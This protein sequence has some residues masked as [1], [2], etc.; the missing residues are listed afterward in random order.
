MAFLASIQGVIPILLII[1]LGYEMQDRHFVS[2]DFTDNVSKII[3][4]IALPAAVFASMVKY[5]SLDMLG[6]L[7]EGITLVGISV[8]LWYGLGWVWAKITHVPAGRNGSFVAA[9]ANTNTLFIGWPLNLALFGEQAMPY[10]LAY[11]FFCNI[12]CWTIGAFLVAEDP[13]LSYRQKVRRHFD[14]KK[15]VPP[16]LV[17]CVVAFAFL[18]T[19]I[20][21]PDALLNTFNYVGS[22]VTPL[23]LLY[24]GMTLQKAGI[25]NISL[26]R[27]TVASSW[28]RPSWPPS[29]S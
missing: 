10:F 28:R 17:S 12:S 4:N 14:L 5:M 24:I 6:S 2:D 8:L 7:S 9:V 26:D 21:L 19:G 3:M 16:P 15:L 29:S 23:S 27:D 11:F 25:R 13:V 1:L 20:T 22:L 18:L